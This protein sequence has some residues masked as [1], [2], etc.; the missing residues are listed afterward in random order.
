MTI[1]SISGRLRQSTPD[2]E[3]VAH[4]RQDIERLLRL[5]EAMKRLIMPDPYSWE[6][7]FRI[8]R[9][10]YYSADEDRPHRESCFW[11]AY[12][13]ALQAIEQSD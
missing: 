7:T 1:E 5:V 6:D 11:L 13:E 8:S 4:A 10:F 9:C 2:T 12:T 3:I